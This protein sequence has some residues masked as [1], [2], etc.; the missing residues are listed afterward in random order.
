MSDSRPVNPVKIHELL[1]YSR[2]GY[3]IARTRWW[4]KRLPDRAWWHVARSIDYFPPPLP[5]TAAEHE[6]WQLTPQPRPYRCNSSHHAP[7][8]GGKYGSAPSS[9][10]PLEH[11]YMACAHVVDTGTGTFVCGCVR[12]TDEPDFG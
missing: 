4:I 9:F 3:A 5:L 10:L 1:G 8:E 6:A 11:P 2:V 12:H 7:R